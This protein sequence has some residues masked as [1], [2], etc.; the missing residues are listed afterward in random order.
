MYQLLCELRLGDTCCHVQC[1]ESVH[2]WPG[3]GGAVVVKGI[4]L[5][6]VVLWPTPGKEVRELLTDEK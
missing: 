6:V 1:I 4:Q 2:N 3:G 5:V